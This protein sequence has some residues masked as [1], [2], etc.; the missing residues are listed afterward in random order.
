MCA[1]SAGFDTRENVPSRLNWRQILQNNLTLAFYC[2]FLLPS[3]PPHQSYQSLKL[4]ILLEIWRKC[5][6]LSFGSQGWNHSYN[7]SDVWS[8]FS[9]PSTKLPTCQVSDT[10][11]PRLPKLSGWIKLLKFSQECAFLWVVWQERFL[12]FNFSFKAVFGP[13]ASSNR[14]VMSH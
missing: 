3:P 2:L 10:S 12:L 7:P 6:P 1:A 14:H 4:I 9:V 13:E 5:N 11:L 8:R